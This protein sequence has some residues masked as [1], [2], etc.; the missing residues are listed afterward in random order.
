[1]N[2]WVSNFE[3]H[4]FQQT[5]ASLKEHVHE[6]VLDDETVETDVAEV[7]RL[8]KVVTYLAELIDNIDP[9]L[10]PLSTWKNFN[11]QVIPCLTEV[12]NFNSNRNIAH[13]TAAN[14]HADNLLT[15]VRPYMVL[16]KSAATAAS[17]SAAA[18]AKVAEEYVKNLSEKIKSI[19]SEIN[20]IKAKTGSNFE[21]IEKSM[22]NIVELEV[23][24]FGEDEKPG[25]KH[26]LYELFSDTEDKHESICDIYNEILVGKGEELSTAQE[27]SEAKV[28]S[29]KKRKEID[30][31]LSEATEEISELEKFHTTVFGKV[32]DDGSREG[33]LA[34]NL[35]NLKTKL[36]KFEEIQ[37][38]RYQAL[39]DEI[40]SLLPGAT[41]AG[42]ATA[43]REM[44]DSFS[45]P[46]RNSSI[47]FYISV[48]GLVGV[49]FILAV[50]SVGWSQ[51]T[52]RT[53]DTW[54]AVLKTIAYKIPFFAPIVWL[55]FY[56]TKRRSEAQRLQQEYAHKE[57]LAKS[58][59]SYKKQISEFAEK[60]DELLREL[61]R[62][63]IEAVSHNASSTLDGKHGDNMP[64]QEA[65]SIGKTK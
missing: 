62:K 12:T 13:I 27:I 36:T 65:L 4:P 29:V 61:I 14:N 40:E 63:A 59:N 57:A 32:N 2:S 22:S 64:A 5:W 15:Y 30:E 49:S 55:A 35:E 24:L 1:M 37:S 38:D 20:E 46:I 16:P 48:A 17:R 50:Q 54:D 11:N 42:L 25:L 52:F 45:K 51:I 56:A 7:A 53:I 41:S 21:D 28:D 6:I 31:L 3:N 26:E 60:D 8:R 34:K 23:E 47:L 18:Y 39:N 44:K 19:V 9:E 43:Y 58:Y 33:G 10:T